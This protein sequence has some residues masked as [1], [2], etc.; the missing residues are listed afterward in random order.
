MQFN[1]GWRGVLEGIAAS[2]SR[3]YPAILREILEV[4]QLQNPKNWAELGRE[5]MGIIKEEVG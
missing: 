1:H 5:A 3:D 4:L 2:D